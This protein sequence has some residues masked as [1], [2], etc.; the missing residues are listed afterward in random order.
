[1]FMGSSD[2]WGGIYVGLKQCYGKNVHN[3]EAR[4]E[5]SMMKV[6]NERKKDADYYV[7]Y[8]NLL[9]SNGNPKK[10]RKGSR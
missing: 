6:A 3:R 1:M 7:C 8:K 10:M 4:K 9:L 2:N 5:V